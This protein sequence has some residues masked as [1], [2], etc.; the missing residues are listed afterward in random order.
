[1][2]EPI[3]VSNISP[4]R[5][6]KWKRRYPI[7]WD[8]VVRVFDDGAVIQRGGASPEFVREACYR[9]WDLFLSM[10]DLACP[11]ERDKQRMRRRFRQLLAERPQIDWMFPH[12]RQRLD[13]HAMFVKHGM[14]E[15][16]PDERGCDA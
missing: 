14:E 11:T 2:N 6:A 4:E 3:I 13:E 15:L 9:I 1:M 8:T 16:D 10:Y 7:H 12:F 5:L